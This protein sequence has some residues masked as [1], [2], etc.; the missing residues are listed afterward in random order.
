MGQVTWPIPQAPGRAVSSGRTLTPPPPGPT[1]GGGGTPVNYTGAGYTGSSGVGIFF[2]LTQT[3]QGAGY[4]GSL[5]LGTFSAAGGG[6]PH[7]A[8]G[9]GLIVTEKWVPRPQGLARSTR[10]QGVITI[11]GRSIQPQALTRT[12]ALGAPVAISRLYPPGLA[13]ARGIVAPEVL[14]ATLQLAAL[15]RV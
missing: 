11:T 1:G 4:T 14:L 6:P 13:H 9:N 2:V 15:D 10:A 7:R 3:F 12:R 5:G 8:L